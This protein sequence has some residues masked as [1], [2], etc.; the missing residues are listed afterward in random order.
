LRNMESRAKNIGGR[1]K[2]RSSQK[3]GTEII[4]IGKTSRFSR[5]KSL[6]NR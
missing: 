6:L 5:L 4:F 3:T 2:W 1:M